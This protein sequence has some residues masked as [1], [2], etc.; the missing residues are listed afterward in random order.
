MDTELERNSR[1]ATPEPRLQAPGAGIPAA[2]AFVLR[3][4]GFGLISPLVSWNLA[5]RLFQWEGL[6]II[7]LT[8]QLSTEQLTR[9][10]LVPRQTALEDSSRF[11]SP[12]MII[13]HLVIVGDKV[14]N[15]MTRLGRGEHIAEPVRIEDVKPDAATLPR[16]CCT[17][18][19]PSSPASTH[20]REP[21]SRTATPPPPTRTPGW[22][23]SPR[24][25][26]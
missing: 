22:D 6:R 11:W 1:E 16:R 20:R 21:V 15:I 12:A 14:I 24:T 17:I 18:S 2:E 9:R 26:G 13:A 8:E 19:A 7:Q 25:S 10:V 4:I 5:R 23:R 3:T